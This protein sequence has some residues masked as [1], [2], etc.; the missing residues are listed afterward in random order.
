MRS[1][2]TIR[3]DKQTTVIYEGKFWNEVHVGGGDNRV[4]DTRVPQCESVEAAQTNGL[5]YSNGY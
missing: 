1:P 2:R 5:V 4:I 3:A